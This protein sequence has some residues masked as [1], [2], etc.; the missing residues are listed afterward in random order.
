MQYEIDNL[1]ENEGPNQIINELESMYK[2]YKNVLHD[3]HYIMQTMRFNLVSLYSNIG[4]IVDIDVLRRK[5]EFC[6]TLL[7][8]YAYPYNVFGLISVFIHRLLT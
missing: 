6:D 5:I 4:G 1:F 2:A 3:E 7:K 8:V